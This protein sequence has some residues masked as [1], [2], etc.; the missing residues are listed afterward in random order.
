MTPIE[1]VKFW[2]DGQ[3][4]DFELVRVWEQEGDPWA[5]YKNCLTEQVY[6]AR[7]EAFRARFSPMPN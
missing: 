5:E 6:T 7:L 4:H 3:G 2:N 1:R